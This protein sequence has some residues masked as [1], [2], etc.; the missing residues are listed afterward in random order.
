MS[1]SSGP[2]PVEQRRAAPDRPRGNAATKLAMDSGMTAS[3]SIRLALPDIDATR[4]LAER[5]AARARAGDIFALGGGLGAGKTTFARGFINA[6]AAGRG[7]APPDEVPS[8]TFTLVQPYEFPGVTVFHFDLYRI[9]TAE[10]THE[11]GF[12]DAFAEGISLIEWPERLAN[13]LPDER[14]DIVL[15]PG[16]GPD[17]R[18]ADLIAHGGWTARIED[19]AR[20]G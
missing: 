19:I 16:A 15:L 10:E 12:E 13:L 9:E 18:I 2:R 5:L 3:S 17:S 6:I 1:A 20:D 11:L 4:L 14:L 7:A 8:P